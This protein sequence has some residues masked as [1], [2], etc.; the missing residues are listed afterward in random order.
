MPI[1]KQ[2]INPK[3]VVDVGCG[4]GGWLA[5]FLKHNI[6]DILG[7]D[8]EYIKQDSLMIDKKDFMSFDLKNPLNIERK[9]DMAMSLE[10]AE[11][12]PKAYSKLF[13]NSLVG[14]SDVVL[15][16][17]AIPFPSGR[18]HVNEQYQSFWI[19]L[20]EKKGYCAIDCIRKKTWNSK[21][22]KWYYSQNCFMFVKKSRLDCYPLLKK[23]YQNTDILYY[24]IVHPE[25]YQRA[26]DI[27]SLR[28]SSIRNIVNILPKL[29]KNRTLKRLK[30]ILW[31]KK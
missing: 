9:F 30:K 24:N 4:A 18:G 21:M 6:D 26:M 11:H 15:F 22:V 31:F 7:I 14:L 20:F 29:I 28:N 10:V 1:I 2:L 12:L 17:A 23:E 27:I 8:G 19:D 5:V 16:S 25:A 3:S 13:V